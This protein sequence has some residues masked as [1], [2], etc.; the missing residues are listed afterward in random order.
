MRK[1]LAGLAICA[2][3][4][5]WTGPVQAQE[6]KLRALS[7]LHMQSA[8]GVMFKAFV[9]Y[10][11][12]NGKGVVQISQ[13]LGPEAIPAFEAG[14]AVMSGV[15]DIGNIPANFIDR[16]IPTSFAGSLATISLDEQR[17]NG[18]WEFMNKQLNTKLNSQMLAIYCQ[19]IAFHVYT[20]KPIDGASLKGMR[21][22]TAPGFEDFVRKLGG[23]ALQMP[24]GDVMTGLE[25]GVVDGYT[26]PLWGIEDLGWIKYTKYRIDPGYWTATNKLVINLDKW[27]SLTQQQRD[28]LSKAGTWL[29]DHT[30]KYVE[31][32]NKDVLKMQADAGIKPIELTGAA[33]AEYLKTAYDSGWEI[34]MRRDPGDAT[35][36]KK[37]LVK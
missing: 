5:S 24:P 15:V 9:D 30:L 20:T 17:K 10:V 35:A 12:E 25:R 2:A 4:L 26:W 3:A 33:A 1:I 18:A 13:V 21:I 11:N 36:L 34:Q 31:A 19:G 16:I 37:L 29:E 8:W 28:F 6:V 7:A 27:K 32:R 22:R 23:E 14:N